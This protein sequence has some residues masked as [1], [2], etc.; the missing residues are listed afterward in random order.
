[1]PIPGNMLS[2]VVEMV[3]PNISGWTPMLNATINAGTGGR[4]GDGCLVV[5]SIA[6]GEMRAR[7]VSSYPVVEGVV[8]QAIGDAAGA[9]VPERIGIRWLSASNSEISITWSLTTSAAMATWHRV[10]VAAPAPVGAAR[11]QIV[12]S[13]TPA[14]A[15]VTNFYENFYLGLPIRMTGNM[16]SFAAE[17]PE[18]DTSAW[19]AETNA[20]LGRAIPPASW[21][22]AVMTVGGHVWTLTATANGNASALCVE[23]APVVVGTDYMAF[24]YLNPPTSGST[25]WIELRYYDGAGTQ[26]SAVRSVLAAPGTGYYRQRASSPAPAGA[27]TCSVAVGITGATAGQ[28]VRFEAVGIGPPPKLN[29]DSL[30]PYA[31]ASFEQGIGGWTK[32]SGV[33]VL[34]RSSPW[35]TG[36]EGSYCLTIASATAT[37]TVIRSPLYDL[38]EPGMS[39]RLRIVQ[40]N[41]VGTWSVGM[42]IRFYDAVGTDLGVH[43]WVPIAVP[44][45]PG[46]S[47]VIL[48]SGTPPAGAT[49]AAAEL[50]LVALSAAATLRLDVITLWPGLPDME[51]AVVEATGSITVTL[52]NL[53]VGHALRLY[54]VDTAGNRT[55]VRG[56]YG[57]WDGTDL[58]AT[59]S[60]RIE[61]YEAPLGMPIGHLLETIDP[62]TKAVLWRGTVPKTIPWPDP[63]R[64]WLKDPGNPQRN[65]IVTVAAQPSWTRPIEQA[66]YVV[67]GRRN[68]VVL[69]G[70][71]QGREGEVQVWTHSDQERERLDWLLD[72]NVLLWQTGPGLGVGDLYMSVGQTT[73]AREGEAADPVRIW[74]LPVTEMDMPVTT[75]VN[76]SGGRT[77][78]DVLS[79]F[80]TWRAVLDA[81]ATW[82][83][84]L[85]NRRKA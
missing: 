40:Q 61:D 50:T 25:V 30:L 10:S 1:M 13:S 7:T 24:A 81:Y 48:T 8:Y 52:R 36:G 5:K 26:I 4:N 16:L 60:M 42:G 35:G 82:E 74:T 75:G 27:V 64:A 67:K 62:D 43:S 55:L 72:G 83:D 73:E 85:L 15:L 28:V 31:D 44:A 76:G 78:Q 65:T 53:P 32:I 56:P 54:R 18:I 63:D 77:W 47:G 17:S 80:P 11:A 70:R 6:A 34:A 9:T 33:G 68:K 58:I 37:T 71:R 45:G 2:S 20:T 29:G 46:W 51:S 66:E 23:R 57:L 38:K 41:A 12:V 79:E 22:A 84:V 21:A 14:A 59:D 19:A 39:H 3:D 69:S 49:R